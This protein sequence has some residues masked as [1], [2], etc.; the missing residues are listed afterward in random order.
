[1]AEKN[2]TLVKTSRYV[3][4]GTTEVNAN[5]IEWW[6]RIGFSLNIDDTTYVVE[7]AL[8][9][10]LD[11]ITTMFYN[12]PRVW[13][14]VAQYNNILDPYGEITEGVVLN[15]P[16]KSRLQALLAGTPGGVASTREV[17]IAILPIV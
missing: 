16:S 1:M 10:R 8:V 14:V 17:P 15:M 5:A 12:E 9:G 4:G 3:S 2:S 13:W 11:L 6:D 7:K